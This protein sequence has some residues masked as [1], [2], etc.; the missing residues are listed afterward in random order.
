EIRKTFRIG[1]FDQKAGLLLAEI[2][3]YHYGKKE[4]YQ[5][6]GITKTQLKY[7]ALI[8]AISKTSGAEC[9]FAHDNDCTKISGDFFPVKGLDGRPDSILKEDFFGENL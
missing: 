6:L 2:L 1:V 3:N 5:S 8:V 7:D 9:L 4:N